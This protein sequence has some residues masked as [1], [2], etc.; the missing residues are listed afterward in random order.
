MTHGHLESVVRQHLVA[1][2]VHQVVARQQVHL[3]K[4]E[5]I[6]LIFS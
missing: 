4:M 5:T 6:L 2:L 1:I 3:Q